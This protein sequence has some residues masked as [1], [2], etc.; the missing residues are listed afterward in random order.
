MKSAKQ[1]RQEI[2]AKRL[3]KQERVKA[4]AQQRAEA[5]KQAEL[6]RL[7][8][9]LEG[10]KAASPVALVDK[11]ALAPHGSYDV[12]LFVQRGYYMD[13][14]FTCK[15][16]GKQEVWSATR[17]KWWY[18]VAK[19]NVWTTACRCRPC[20]QRERARREAARRVHLEGL[21]RKRGDRDGSVAGPSAERSEQLN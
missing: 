3:A 18:E 17:Q 19:G 2:R 11:T 12:P 13:L 4:I 1:R 6:E 16:C 15:D 7:R 5:E 20:R 21:A 10:G 8:A 9:E 14:P